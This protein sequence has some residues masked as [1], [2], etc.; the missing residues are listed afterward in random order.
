MNKDSDFDQDEPVSTGFLGH[1]PTI[2]W[3]RRWFIIWPAVVCSI[4]GTVTA[5]SLSPVYQSKAI[6]LVEAQQ[7]P[8]ELIGPGSSSLI[9]KRMARIREQV[10]SRPDLVGLIQKNDLY[11]AERRTKPLSSVIEIMRNAT[12]M[13][14]VTAG[15]SRDDRESNTIAFQLTFDYPDPAKA[16]IVASDYVDRLLKLDAAQTAEKAAG[17]VGFLEEEAKGLTDQISVVEGQIESIKGKNGIALSSAGTMMLTG[18]GGYDSQIASLQRENNQLK[19]QLDTLSNP[20]QRDPNVAAAEAQLANARA[21][22]SDSYPDVRIAEQKLAEAKRSAGRNVNA[23]VAVNAANSQ[24]A[25]NNSMIESLLAA[26]GRDASRTSSIVAAQSR[27]PLVGEQIS[28]LQSRADQLRLSYQGV[29]NNLLN[30][31]AAVRM[32]SENKGERLSIIDP[33]VVSDQPLRPNRLLILAAGIGGGLLLGL[34]LALLVEFIRRPIRG[35][36]AVKNVTGAEPL[37]VVPTLDRR[38]GRFRSRGQFW[39]RRQMT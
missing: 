6:L 29:A 38:V 28:Q 9:D 37:V 15:T 8:S 25:A 34:A 24:I 35:V 19:A 22:Y 17:T 32:G 18:G 31:R 11:P 36:G 10:L 3:E 27:A 16:R 7:L 23:E 33:P 5:Y 1:I 13:T 30:A 21:I 4:A 2:L 26:K 39:K 12:A 20:A 14:P